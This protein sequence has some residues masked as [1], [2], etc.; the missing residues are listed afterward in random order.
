MKRL[1]HFRNLL[2]AYLNVIYLNKHDPAIDA[3]IEKLMADGEFIEDD[4]FRAVFEMG[5]LKFYGVWTANR[6][7][8]YASQC[9]KMQ[10]LMPGK[11]ISGESLWRGARPSRKTMVKLHEFLEERRKESMLKRLELL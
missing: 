1:R 6:W 2:S 5:E 10:S 8:G 7:Y 9:N 3:F 11:F 4:R